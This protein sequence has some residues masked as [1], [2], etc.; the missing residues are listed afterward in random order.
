MR[1]LLP[2]AVAIVLGALAACS[3]SSSSDP[4]GPS[5]IDAGTLDPFDVPLEGVTHDQFVRF[6][7]GDS[8][9]DLSLRSADGLGPL[10]TRDSCGGCH[11][12]AARGPGIVQK[13]SVVEAD[14]ITA[15]PADQQQA[16]LPYGGT[17]H[18]QLVPGTGVTQAIVPPPN[19]A[20]VKVT[21][22]LGPPVL[23]RGYM[24]AILD[25][26]ILRVESEQAARTDAIHGH[27]NWVTYASERNTDTSVHAHAK[28]DK[29]IGRFGFKARVGYLDD[30]TADALQGDMGITSPLRPTEFANPDH[31]T[32]DLKP[33][34]DATYDD[35]NKRANYVRLI[36][37]PKRNVT[38]QGS[39]LFASTQCAACHVPSM[40]TRSD[41]PVSLLAGI[42]A[43]IYSDLLL[44]D[45]G[46][47]LADGT[48]GLDGQATS[49]QW[50]TAPLIGLRF[51]KVFMHDGRAKSIADAIAAHDSAGSEAADSVHRF[52]ALSADD[53]KTLLDFVGAL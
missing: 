34:I 45:M 10:Y 48:A 51:A 28:G 7:D 27:V 49:R 44:H 47:A 25:S 1:S 23:G 32:D 13:M 20:S 26:E 11:R 24:E 5:G 39:A 38:D 40:K 9:F 36:A 35:V 3:S 16:K 19:D 18:P 50:R 41:Y 15:A 2:V 52:Q 29:V 37:I 17:V 53:Q 8:L 31:V 33:G 4:S 43:P 14:G 22:R 21:S 46:D 42:D 12:D 30:F 6:N